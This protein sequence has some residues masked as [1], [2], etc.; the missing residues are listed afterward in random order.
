MGVYA[1]GYPGGLATN[2]LNIEP[3][4]LLKPKD[5]EHEPANLTAVSPKP[6]RPK[7]VTHLFGP[8]D[9]VNTGA[10][11]PRSML[12]E[13]NPDFDHPSYD[14]GYD[15]NVASLRKHVVKVRSQLV[16]V[17]YKPQLCRFHDFGHSKSG[18]DEKG[19]APSYKSEKVSEGG[20][21]V[22]GFFMINSTWRLK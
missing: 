3:R 17:A 19:A 16:L 8:Y 12:Q 13:E 7:P 2:C 4:L 10:L 11:G 22:K 6:S 14:P 21:L 5:P 1:Q 15:V 18:P 9:S 20:I